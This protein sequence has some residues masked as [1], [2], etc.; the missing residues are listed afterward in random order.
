[1]DETAIRFDGVHKRF[2]STEALSGFTGSVP[3]GSISALLGR[4]GAGKT[5]ALKTLV[6]LLRPDAGQVPVFGKSSQALDVETRQRI[7]Y[8]SE[9]QQLDGRLTVVQLISYTAAFYPDWDQA[10]A[11][12]LVDRLGLLPEQLIGSLSQGE[13]RKLSLL[14]NLAFRPALLVL[15]EPAANLDAVVRREFLETVLELFRGEG[16]TVLLSTHLLGD[17]ERIADRVI[18]I[19]Q[20]RLRVEANLDDLKDR[21]KALRFV[22]ENGRPVAE[23]TLPGTL[24]RRR[25]GSELLITVESYNEPAARAAA[26]AAGAR[27]EVLDLPLEEIFIAYSS[28][29]QF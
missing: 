18:L 19:E 2:G 3:V 21:V 9:R 6:G 12:D 13:G 16:L 29:E 8:V 15:D 5:T 26:E 10:L 11:A 22:P 1:M 7:G 24:S 27:L 20:G 4:N 28:G 17:V 23:I 25:S 14:L